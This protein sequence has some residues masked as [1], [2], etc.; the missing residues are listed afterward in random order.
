MFDGTTIFHKINYVFP[1]LVFFSLALALAIRR[2][3]MRLVLCTLVYWIG[4]LFYYL[5]S[6]TATI[7]LPEIFL[8]NAPQ[9]WLVGRTAIIVLYLGMIILYMVFGK[10]I[11]FRISYGIMLALVAS[12]YLFYFG[13]VL[14]SGDD[15]GFLLPSHINISFACLNTAAPLISSVALALAL[16][17]RK[18]YLWP[19]LVGMS[20]WAWLGF[21]YTIFPFVYVCSPGLF[22][23]YIWAIIRTFILVMYS[24]MIA[25]YTILNK[26]NLFW[27]SFGL[28]IFLLIEQFY[29]YFWGEYYGP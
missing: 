26:R 14:T 28:T 22:D 7:T 29:S 8:W 1:L 11:L 6:S 15:F 10:S 3:H 18:H 24:I 9:F 19:I 4:L 17:V 5:V 16:G 21:Y 13:S 27:I 25:L 2:K 20:C 12:E 23:F